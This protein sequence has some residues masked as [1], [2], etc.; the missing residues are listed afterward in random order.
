MAWP[1]AL[2]SFYNGGPLAGAAAM[3]AYSIQE[4]ARLAQHVRRVIE[5]GIQEDARINLDRDR[6]VGGPVDVVMV[7]AK[8]ARC[9]PSC[10]PP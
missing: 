10:S 8:G 5:E 2:D 3:F 4:P 6:H 1:D 9:V 7:D